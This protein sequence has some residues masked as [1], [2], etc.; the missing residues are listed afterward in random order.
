[1]KANNFRWGEVYVFHQLPFVS[2]LDANK[3][4]KVTSNKNRCVT[5]EDEKGNSVDEIYA[6]I[7]NSSFKRVKG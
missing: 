4:Y 1:M 5:F 2:M 3:E 7:E 6:V